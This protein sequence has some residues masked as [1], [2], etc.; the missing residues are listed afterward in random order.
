M[1]T[2]RQLGGTGLQTA[3][4]IMWL[5]IDLLGSQAQSGWGGGGL[6]KYV[7][8]GGQGNSTVHGVGL[9]N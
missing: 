6:I 1:T 4:W 9:D 7:W 8:E 5:D 3:R 2:T